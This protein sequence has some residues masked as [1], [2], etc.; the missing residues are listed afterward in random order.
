MRAAAASLQLVCLCSALALAACGGGGDG[1]GTTP[2][3]TT[4]SDPQNSTTT[5]VK[6]ADL[7][8][9]WFACTES[10]NA[11]SLQEKY[12]FTADSATLVSYEYV[13]TAYPSTDCT[14]TSAGHLKRAGKVQIDGAASQVDGVTPQKVTFAPKDLA[15]NG[16]S[17]SGNP[18]ATYKQLLAITSSGILKEGDTAQLDTDGYPTDL[19][20][21][22]Y[23]KAP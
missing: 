12:T 20:G 4:Q 11:T 6:A 5:G 13:R 7:N 15:L 3:A 2:P 18:T 14:G 9:T 16:M 8:G 17:F 10:S 21:L 19:S 22:Q 23:V 1:G